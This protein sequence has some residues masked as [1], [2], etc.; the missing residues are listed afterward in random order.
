MMFYLAL[1]P[2]IIDLGA[3]TVL[4][5]AELTLTMAV[6]LIAIDLAW[7]LAAAQARRLLK[8]ERAMRIA[9]RVSAT[10]MARRGGGDRRALVTRVTCGRHNPFICR[11]HFPPSAARVR[12][13]SHCNLPVAK[14]RPSATM[15]AKACFGEGFDAWPPLAQN[16]QPQP[17]SRPAS[18][19]PGGLAAYLLGPRACRR[20]RRL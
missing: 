16:P 3:V 20:R 19:K 9:N 18:P 1:L 4:G 11:L 5:W 2:T 10:T 17:E 8:S 13:N 12:R 6:V 7:V 15:T 14:R